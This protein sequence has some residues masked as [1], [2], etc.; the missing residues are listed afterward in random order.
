[1][2]TADAVLKAAKRLA[3]DSDIEGSWKQG[4]TYHHNPGPKYQALGLGILPVRTYSKDISPPDPKW[5]MR[6]SEH[7]REESSF[8]EFWAGL[9]VDHPTT[10]VK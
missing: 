3:D 1:M 7:T 2:P 8:D 4:R 5:I 9:G 10:E 6:V